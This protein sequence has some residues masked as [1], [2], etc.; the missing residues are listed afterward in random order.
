M[1]T[2]RILNRDPKKVFRLF[3]DDE[4]GKVPFK[5]LKRAAKELSEHMTDEELQEVQKQLL[6]M[7]GPSPPSSS[8][9]AALGAA[10]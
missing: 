6:G 8:T 9:D 5:H 10:T 7:S 3:D 1:T 4:T 2:L